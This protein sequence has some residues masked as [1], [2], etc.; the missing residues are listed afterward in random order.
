MENKYQKYYN[1]I[2][3]FI[4]IGFIAFWNYYIILYEVKWIAEKFYVNVGIKESTI[5]TA[6]DNKMI[7]RI[8]HFWKTNKSIF[9]GPPSA[10]FR[11]HSR[12]ALVHGSLVRYIENSFNLVR[13]FFVFFSFCKLLFSL[14]NI[15]LCITNIIFYPVQCL[16]LRESSRFSQIPRPRKT[17]TTNDPI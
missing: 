3:L 13:G 6:T 8:I 2:S 1:L 12:P 9:D 17:S 11:P 4:C 7:I 16:T 5:I 15:F 10:R 14:F